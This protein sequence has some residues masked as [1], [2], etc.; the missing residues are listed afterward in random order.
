MRGPYE[1]GMGQGPG[2]VNVPGGQESGWVKESGIGRAQLDRGLEWAGVWEGARAW[3]RQWPGRVQEPGVVQ[4][5][6][7]VRAWVG[8]RAWKEQGS[9]RE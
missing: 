6:G 4:E 9:G 3:N 1:D 2:S 5:P 8:A 7:G